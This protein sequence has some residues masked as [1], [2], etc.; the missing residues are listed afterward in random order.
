M[1]PGKNADYMVRIK[2][3]L[4]KSRRKGKF[5]VLTRVLG[6]AANGFADLIGAEPA[7]EGDTVAEYHD[8]LMERYT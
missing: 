3:E 4:M 5:I 6:L 8:H 2:V 1:T 7:Y